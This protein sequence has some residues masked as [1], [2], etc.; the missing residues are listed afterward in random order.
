[1]VYFGLFDVKPLV[2]SRRVTGV[3]AEATAA[4]YEKSLEI[5]ATAA[6]VAVRARSLE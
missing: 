3:G 4:S 1:M 6:T 5:R 2:R